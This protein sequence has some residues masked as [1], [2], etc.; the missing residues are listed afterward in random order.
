MI[1]LSK[2][3]FNDSVELSKADGNNAIGLYFDGPKEWTEHMEINTDGIHEFSTIFF[4]ISKYKSP[5]PYI[6]RA[7]IAPTLWEETAETYFDW[8]FEDITDE[9]VDKLNIT[10]AQILDLARKGGCKYI[11]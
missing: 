10:A 1:D 3:R 5:T 8:D 4:V 9:V 7:E 6:N 2:L 11:D